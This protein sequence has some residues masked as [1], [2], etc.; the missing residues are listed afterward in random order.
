M[1]NVKVKLFKNYNRT[2][3]RNIQAAKKYRILIN[4][5]GTSCFSGDQLVVTKEGSKPIASIK[6]GDIVKCYNE[7]T[8]KDE[9]R[10]VLNTFEYENHKKTIKV[11]LKNGKTIVATA[12][13]KFYHDG[14][15]VPLETLLKKKDGGL[16]TDT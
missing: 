5:G 1:S 9:W 7:V 3:R 6:R 11:T 8:E 4:Q 16:E 12:D 14:E 2:Y 10:G 13:H 15:W